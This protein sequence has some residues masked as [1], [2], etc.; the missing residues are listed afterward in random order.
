M[1]DRWQGPLVP[2]YRLSGKTPM[3]HRMWTVVSVPGGARIILTTLSTPARKYNRGNKIRNMLPSGWLVWNL[4]FGISAS[5]NKELTHWWSFFCLVSSRMQCGQA[6]IKKLGS[7]LNQLIENPST[8]FNIWNECKVSVPPCVLCCVFEPTG[9]GISRWQRYLAEKTVSQ[10][11]HPLHGRTWLHICCTT[12]RS[13]RDTG[14]EIE[15]S[16]KVREDFTVHWDA[17]PKIS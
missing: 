16:T 2:N 12:I 10:Q 1:Y 17:C 8:N 15:A 6:W 3:K 9:V 7:E 4:I 5:I 14:W 11:L 13:C